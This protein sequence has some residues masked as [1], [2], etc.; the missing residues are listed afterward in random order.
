MK[1]IRIFMF[2]SKHL[3]AESIKKKRFPNSSPCEQLGMYNR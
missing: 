1:K 3:Q 2:Y